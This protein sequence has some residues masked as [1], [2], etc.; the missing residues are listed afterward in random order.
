[1]SAIYCYLITG[2]PMPTLVEAVLFEDL[3]KLNPGDVCRRALCRYDE[4]KKYYQ[5][6]VWGDDYHIFPDK[7]IIEPV[8]RK[9]QNPSEYLDV[10]IINY[11]LQTRAIEPCNTWISEKDIPGGATFFRGPHEI[12]TRLISSRFSGDIDGFRKT[13][14]RLQGTDLD[15]ADSAYVFK[16]TPRLLVAVLYWEADEDFPSEAKVLFDKTIIDHLALD[17]IFALAVDI[18]TRIGQVEV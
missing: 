15:M 10:F 11:L 3:A 7:K 1:M 5:L 14:E 4:V 18:C 17:I 2:G 13:C 6:N 16:I 9:R 12:P 8:S